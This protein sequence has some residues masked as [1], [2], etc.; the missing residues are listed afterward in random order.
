MK[1]FKIEKNIPIPKSEKSKG[2]GYFGALRKMEVGDSFK[3]DIKLRNRVSGAASYLKFRHGLE[4][5][6]RKIDDKEC[7]CWRVK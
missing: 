4:F 5:I 3:F 1:E 7:R 6:M 2:A